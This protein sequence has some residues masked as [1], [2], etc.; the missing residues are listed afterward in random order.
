MYMPSVTLQNL[1]DKTV[2]QKQKRGNQHL[3]VFHL[4]WR[5]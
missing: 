4:L 3:T 1:I 5:N 2:V